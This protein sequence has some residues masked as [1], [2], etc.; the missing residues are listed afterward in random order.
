MISLSR[1]TIVAAIGSI[2]ALILLPIAAHSAVDN[3]ERLND[4]ETLVGQSVSFYT[5]PEPGGDWGISSRRAAP[6]RHYWE[7]R[8]LRASNFCQ[9]TAKPM[10]FFV[11]DPD[12][13]THA[14]IVTGPLAPVEV[15]SGSTLVWSARQHEPVIVPAGWSVGARW[16]GTHPEDDTGEKC[17]WQYTAVQRPVGAPV[18]G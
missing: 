14:V 7:V 2:T 16:Y 17:D 6:A 1:R 5:P 10:E 13:T 3:A 15:A 9:A 12:G 8:T 18:G 4:R 11:A